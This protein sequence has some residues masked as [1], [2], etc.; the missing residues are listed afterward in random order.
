M[1]EADDPA[2]TDPV[3]GGPKTADPP[4]DLVPSSEIFQTLDISPHLTEDQ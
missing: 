1:Y 4:P 2:A 3:K